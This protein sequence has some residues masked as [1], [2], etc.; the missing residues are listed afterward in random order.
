MELS[1]V[2]KVVFWLFL[3]SG[4]GQEG[5]GGLILEP[6]D[7]SRRGA[8]G[9]HSC[10]AWKHSWCMQ[11]HTK[12]FEN[13]PKTGYRLFAICVYLTGKKDFARFL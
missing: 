7:A 13:W 5:F 8:S 9:L 1:K 11:E 12:V 4:G 6:L 10:V 2:E 3:G